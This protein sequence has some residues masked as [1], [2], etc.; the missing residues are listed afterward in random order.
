MVTIQARK[1]AFTPSHPFY[2]GNNPSWLKHQMENLIT[3]LNYF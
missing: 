1:T 3:F 2:M